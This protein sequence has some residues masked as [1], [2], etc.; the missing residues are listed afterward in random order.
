MYSY[1]LYYLFIHTTLS[2][3]TCTRGSER[4]RVRFRNQNHIFQLEQSKFLRRR[5][6]RR[7]RADFPLANDAIVASC[8]C[9]TAILST[10]IICGKGPFTFSSFSLYVINWNFGHLTWIPQIGAVCV[11]IQS[12]PSLY[13]NTEGHPLNLIWRENFQ[14]I[15]RNSFFFHLSYTASLFHCRQPPAGGPEPD[16]AGQ[17]QRL[18][19]QHQHRRGVPPS[20]RGARWQRQLHN[21]QRRNDS[22]RDGQRPLT[23][24]SKVIVVLSVR[25]Q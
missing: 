2:V 16:L 3:V 25:G 20:P 23:I 19:R 5:H 7:P 24:R 21:Y 1:S 9:H 14:S 12:H 6:H 17:G 4:A 10:C 18:H 15:Q 11:Q 22:N 13:T 8:L